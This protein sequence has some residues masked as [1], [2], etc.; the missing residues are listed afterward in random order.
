M[1]QRTK[2]T[3]NDLSKIRDAAMDQYLNNDHD[4]FTDHEFIGL[5]F[6]RAFIQIMPESIK[7]LVELPEK[8]IYT[9]SLD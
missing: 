8:R 5:C 2:L 4:G 6:A 3:R 1:Q 7:D 9:E